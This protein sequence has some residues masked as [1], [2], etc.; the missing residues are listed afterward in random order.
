M[1]DWLPPFGGRPDV[2]KLTHGAALLF[3]RPGDQAL[4]PLRRHPRKVGGDSR[5]ADG[6]G[7]IFQARMDIEQGEPGANHQDQGENDGAGVVQ[8]EGR[9]VHNGNLRQVAVGPLIP[10]AF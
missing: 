3:D 6:D 9:D 10:T 2:A 8:R 4:D 7:R 5:L 1:N